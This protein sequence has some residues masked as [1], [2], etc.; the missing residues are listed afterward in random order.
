MYPTSFDYYRPKNLKEAIALLRKNKDAKLLAGGHSLLPAMKLRVSSPSALIDIARI[1]G[2]DGIKVTK[3]AAK[4]GGMT[5]HGA[6][7]SSKE[8]R[9]ACPVLSEAAAQIGDIQVRNRGTI[10]GSLA[11]ADPAADYPTVMLALDAEIVA[12][13]AKGKRKIGADKFFVDL[14]TTGLKAGEVLTEVS[15]PAMKPGQGACYLKH[16]HPASSY[17]VVGI[18]AFVTLKGGFV[19]DVRLV[20][21]GV[22]SIPVLVTEVETSLAERAPSAKAIAEACETVAEALEYPLGDVYASGE[23]RTHLAT[24]LSRRALSEACARAKK[25]K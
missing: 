1:K 16:R 13:G 10:G 15:V 20:V 23:Y 22:T 8:L 5:T 11:H 17:A 24:V 21:G 7:E 25:Q 18:A 9:K 4:I 3:S 12:T 19:K 14:F 2:L 6:V